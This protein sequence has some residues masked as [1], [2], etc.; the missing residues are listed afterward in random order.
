MRGN[1]IRGFGSILFVATL[2]ALVGSVFVPATLEAARNPI[3]KSRT[4]RNAIGATAADV[5]ATG[6][7]LI[8]RCHKRRD[9]T[10]ADVDCNDLSASDVY[11]R[12]RNLFRAKVELLCKDDSPVRGNYPGGDVG[13]SVVPSITAAV[14][15]SATS[16]QGSPVFVGKPSQVKALSKCHGAIGRGRTKTVKLALNAIRKCQMAADKKADTFPPLSNCQTA[17]D[18]AAAEGAKAVAKRCDG[19]ELPVVTQGATPGGIITSCSDPARCVSEEAIETA[20][21]IASAAY[22][23]GC[24]NG[25]DEAGE[26]CDDG[27]TDNDDGCS[28]QCRL[29]VCGDGTAQG[30]EECDDG[31]VIGTDHCSATCTLPVC[32]DG[33]QAGDEQC[34]DG[35][36]TVPGDG[37]TNCLIDAVACSSEGTIRFK[38]ALEFPND[39]G[40]LVGAVGVRVTYPATMSVPSF[41]L[42]NGV[43]FVCTPADGDAGCPDVRFF[44][45]SPSFFGQAFSCAADPA[46]PSKCGASGTADSLFA[47]FSETL[48]DTVVPGNLYEVVFDCEPGMAID[49]S[50]V[51]C[52]VSEAKD[53]GSNPISLEGFRCNLDA[54]RPGAATGAP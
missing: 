16:V 4:C 6:L 36:D 23:G 9:N 34:D 26:Q 35:D 5:V 24:G 38:T 22:G 39:L 41:P 30:E 27:N 18:G 13:A 37:C 7:R 31:N 29:P 50:T 33:V 15:E 40:V 51:P 45:L 3:K 19:L 11:G 32:G 52:A 25:F 1:I 20:H 8:D 48:P 54:V 12:M 49:P 10:Q 17:G 43:N 53:P 46:A 2:A 47:N 42:G 28:N 44:P 21:R 14:L